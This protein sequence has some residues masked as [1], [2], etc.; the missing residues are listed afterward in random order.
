MSFCSERHRL[1][2]LLRCHTRP[3]LPPAASLSFPSHL[4]YGRFVPSASVVTKL[5]PP[6][7]PVFSLLII[8]S[9]C[10][11]VLRNRE[12]KV[13]PVEESCSDPT[14]SP[15]PFLCVTASPCWCMASFPGKRY[16]QFD[17]QGLAPKRTD[18]VAEHRCVAAFNCD[19]VTLEAEAGGQ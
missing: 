3:F 18:V 16:S 4:A 17:A 5:L 13:N 7:C 9:E 10:I 2:M 14:S 12:T 1:W 8:D 6:L 19:P 15:T 11:C